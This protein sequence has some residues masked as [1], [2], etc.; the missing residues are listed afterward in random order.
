MPNLHS[1]LHESQDVSIIEL[2]DQ[3]DPKDDPS[4][5]LY[6]LARQLSEEHVLAPPSV[7]PSHH[8]FE[9]IRAQ[10]DQLDAVYQVFTSL[11]EGELA[12]SQATEWLLDNYYVL[13]QAIQQLKESLPLHYYEEMPPLNTPTQYSG[14]PRIYVL[15]QAYVRFDLYRVDINRMKQFALAYQEAAPL[16]IGELWALPLWLRFT[17]LE[18]LIQ[19]ANQLVLPSLPKTET[20]VPYTLPADVDETEVI[21][22]CVLSLRQLAE[23]DWNTF[24][25]EVSLVEQILR[26]DP[27]QVYG[28]MVFKTRDQYRKTVETLARFSDYSETAVAQT[29]VT[30]AQLNATHVGYFLINRGRPQLEQEIGYR[31]PPFKRFQQWLKQH[32]TVLYIGSINSIMLLILAIILWYGFLQNPSGWMLGFIILFSLL[33]AV[34]TAVTLVNWAVTHLKRPRVLPKLDFSEGIPPSC[35]TM[36]VIP[37]LLTGSE[38][39]ESLLQQ[40]EHHY[41]RNSDPQL[42][43]ALLSDF[44]DA[45][46]ETMDTDE[47]LLAQARDGVQ[48][49]NHLYPSRPFYLFHRRRLWNEAKG[50]WMGWERKRGKLHE[51]NR[52]LRGATDTSYVVQEGEQEGL[53]AVR[54]IITLDADTILPLD[55]AARLVGTLAHPLNVAQFDG[56]NNRVVSGYTILQPRVEIQPTNANQS[57]FTRVFAGDT[58]LDLYTLA[59]SDV[60]QDLFGEGSYTGKGIYEIDSFERSLAGRIPE[61][62]LLSHDLFEGIQGRA[63]LVTDVV[64]YEDYPTHYL[65]YL[66]RSHRWMRGDWQLLPWLFPRVPTV[67]GSQRNDL[68]LIHIW[69]ISDNLRRSLHAPAC[70]F[71]FIAAWLLMPGSLLV[72][73]AIGLLLS[74]TGVMT[75]VLTAVWDNV[76]NPSW[77][78]IVRQIRNTVIRWLLF[79]AFLPFETILVINAVAITLWRL[80]ISRR[81][82][83][84]WTTAAHVARLIGPEMTTGATVRHS[85]PAILLSVSVACLILLINP[86][87]VPEAAPMVIIWLLSFVLAQWISQP[88]AGTAEP[89]SDDQQ[90]QL[91]KLARATWLFFEQYVTPTDNWLPPDHFQ[92]SPRGVVAHRTS[93]TNI[94]FY[95]LTALCARDFG[96]ISVITLSLRLRDTFAT[97][98]KMDRY[99]GHFINWIDTTTLQPLSPRYIST[100]D[101]G[102]LAG[103]LLALKQ[104]CLAIEHEPV[105]TWQR[106][107]GLHDLLQLFA[108]YL[109]E[110]AVDGKPLLEKIK[111][112]SDAITAS[113]YQPVIWGQLITQFIETELPDLE[114][115]LL[116]LIQ[117]YPQ[118]SAGTIYHWRVYV[119]R[120]HYNL[121][122]MQREQSL[123]LPWLL[124]WPPPFASNDLPEVQENYQALATLL[125]PPDSAENLPSLADLPEVCRQ[126]RT[127]L[128]AVAK[129][130]AE[131]ETAVAWCRELTGQLANSRMMAE[132]LVTAF[133]ELA[134]DADRLA[135]EMDF[136]FLYNQRRQVF[137]IGYNLESNRLDNNFYDLLASEARLASLFAIAK[138]DVPPSHWLHLARPLTQS[139]GGLALLSWSG[140]M[141]EY[142]TPP[143]LLRSFPGTL[144]HESCRA[145][146]AHQIAYGEAQQVPW[147]ISES[148]YY[149]FDNAQNYQYRAF[150]VPGLGYKRGLADDLVIAPYASIMALPF[151]PQAVLANLARLQKMQ[152]QGICG[153]YEAVDFTPTRLELGQDK[154][155]VC[156]YM[157]HH[158]GMILVT[159]LNVLQNNKMVHRFH[160]NPLVQSVE[161]LMQE[162]VPMRPPLQEP[163]A[164]ETLPETRPK[165]AAITADPW[166]VPTDSALPLVHWLS[167]GRFH[168]LISNAGSGQVQ[169]NGIA[170]TRWRP[171]TT[172]D[173]WGTWVY[174]QDMDNTQCWSTGIQPMGRVSNH[175]EVHFFPHMARFSRH[176]FG[177]GLQTEITIAPHADVEI[178]RLTLTNQTPQPRNL[179]LT[180]YAEVVLTDEVA[181]QRH[182]AFAKLFVESEYVSEVNALLFRRRPR[183][184]KEAPRF[185]AHMLVVGDSIEPTRAYESDRA[186]FLG[187]GRTPR[188]PFALTSAQWLTGT[189]GATLDPI[190]ALGQEVRLEAHAVTQIAFITATAETRAELLDLCRQYRRWTVLNR[191]FSAARNQAEQELRTLNLPVADLAEIQRLL[192]RLLYPHASLRAQPAVL[193][194]NTQGQPALWAYGISGDYPILLVK[195]D[196]E[197]RWLLLQVLLRAHTYWRRRGL[198]IDLVILNQQD[199]NYGQPLEAFIYRLVHQQDS[200]HW[201]NRRGGIFVVRQ[202]QMSEADWTLL[203]TAA[204][205]VLDCDRGSLAAQLADISLRPNPL[206]H[207][208]KARGKR[209]SPEPVPLARPTDLQFDN[210]YG[211]FSAAGKEYVIHLEPGQTTPAPWINVIANETFG[212]L[213]S[214]SGGGYSWAINSGENRLTNWRNDP[215][216]DLPAEALYI[217]D[218]ETAVFWSPVP[219]PR[220]ADAPFTVHHG[221]GYSRF[222]H[223]SHHLRQ[224][225]TLFVPPDAPLKIVQLKLENQSQQPRRFTVTY[226]AEWV[227]GVT[228]STMQLFVQPWY[229]PDHNALM[230][231]NPY[232]MD[233]GER[234]A[235]LAADRTPHGYTTDRTSFLGRLG[236]LQ[237]PD[238]LFRIGL[239]NR[240]LSGLDPCAALQIHVSLEPGAGQTVTFLLGQAEDE[241]AAVS[242]IEKFR[243]PQ[244]VA[245]AWRENKAFWDKILGTVQVATPDPGLD[246]LLN[247]WLL[248]QSLACR[249]W[250]RSALYQSSG[251]YGFRDQLQDVMAL[252]HTRPDLVRAHLLRSARH[253]FEAGDVLHWWHP[254]LARGVRT[255]ITDDLVWLPFV[256]AEY[257]QATGD[258]AVLDKKI[259]YLTADPLVKDEEDRYGLYE[260][261]EELYTL[262][263]HCCRALERAATC[264]E[265]GLPLMGAGDW[266]DGMNR[267]G[268]EGAGESVWLGWFLYEALQRFAVICQQRD[269][270]KRA[271]HLQQQAEAYRQAIETHAWDGAWYRRAYYDDGTPLGAAQNEECRID[272]LAQ[273]WGVLT[274]AAAKDRATQAMEAVHRML[275]KED[276]RLILLFT[277]PFDRTDKDPGYI[278]GYLP[279]IREN[280]GQ[281][282]HAAMWTIWAFA[283]LGEADTAVSLYRL[284]NPIYRADTAEKAARYKVEPYVIS[285]DVYGVPPHQGRGGWTWYTGSSGWMYRLGIEGIL[286]LHRCGSHLQ[287]HPRIPGN[288]P[289]YRL[290]YRYGITTYKIA[291]QRQ[292]EGNS[293]QQVTLDGK[294]LTDPEIKLVNDGRIHDVQITIG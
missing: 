38:E 232:N 82:L 43:F 238:A 213:V 46:A 87:A 45:E 129:L 198:K 262:Y 49:L 57:I 83:L 136:S 203:Q 16:K 80:F 263:D 119:E 154:A 204:R 250:G 76:P 269:D 195:I 220:P 118:A 103:C 165:E 120:L 241:E 231:K 259:P 194:T 152:M 181:D 93:P 214:E 148:G 266:N 91:Y 196:D 121:I 275:V 246:L 37:C 157:A 7:V 74:G 281:Y 23:Q 126:A 139:T 166:Q 41:L 271:R 137:H 97:L 180:S 66:R 292:G 184:A 192:S 211:G 205:V 228:R 183:S 92:E 257:V 36:V 88:M 47:P 253:Q 13:Q 149:A 127:R 249:I 68:R 168:T 169:S 35:R 251:A 230:V 283:D 161:L 221:A 294:A 114:Q 276:E 3:P 2:A 212:F 185:L 270:D 12:Y 209:L 286:G 84:Q 132:S 260:T 172:Q 6:R 147:G 67:T 140:T 290:T 164:D 258:T 138:R 210:G 182:Q 159:L 20:A 58:G 254:P 199:T 99:R 9:R 219:Q 29:V 216:T 187:R 279:G 50:C 100:V 77:P 78:Q 285:A 56:S 109:E 107:R 193:A 158:Q 133:E 70:F 31:L 226:Y 131:D 110:T 179:R 18:S 81:N 163:H 1:G 85:L 173:N 252:L 86:A 125:I 134:R 247:Q 162:Q 130:L 243:Q 248:Y 115:R 222:E 189:T 4:R 112:I 79:I 174:V 256:T 14:F 95:L 10:A 201:I 144:L 191:A 240:I 25:E 171:D 22:Y 156:S 27:A 272:S 89:L 244:R 17:L 24:F 278:K 207:L 218:E 106:W 268:I 176:D 104:G 178:R 197:E 72:W 235:F 111:Q 44:A 170:C 206:P 69:K 274:G 225:T 223:I 59:V 90:Q 261:T 175:H 94:G 234:I 51:F 8:F 116:T 160:A 63:G 188:T 60:Y 146:V 26:Q 141:F 239:D 128:E 108:D 151:R 117:Q 237:R 215:V 242:L 145:I 233:F 287:I 153:L 5:P 53:T 64:L 273:S 229:R 30:L 293:V 75:T 177:I 32:P 19:A 123:L 255:R 54:Y 150:G 98:A 40:L 113:R 284:M 105:W 227:L 65:T 33:P 277:P 224:E 28:Q 202:D 167:N 236:S 289:G 52:L 62:S 34:D 73:T 245:Q 122:G 142:L 282:T 102:N 11:T 61:N 288:W 208:P 48:Q 135:H 280:G 190:M 55:A 291:V 200:G 39:V 186:A 155:R 15:A 124:V 101:S 264:G 265:H 217:R 267:V 96:Y 42:G 71:F 21:S 143:L